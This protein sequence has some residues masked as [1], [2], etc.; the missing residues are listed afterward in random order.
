M[1]DVLNLNKYQNDINLALDGSIK[2]T[3]L[4]QD[5]SIADNGVIGLPYQQ[6]LGGSV[7]VLHFSS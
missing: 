7:Q 3:V 6:Y 1:S 4:T 2:P 5:D